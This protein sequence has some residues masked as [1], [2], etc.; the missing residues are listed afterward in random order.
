[1][2]VLVDRDDGVWRVVLEEDDDECREYLPP[3][4]YTAQRVY[5]DGEP[6]TDGIIIAEAVKIILLGGEIHIYTPAYAG[7]RVARLIEKRYSRGQARGRTVR[8]PSP[9][10]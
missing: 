4:E 2:K 6:V 1:M 8:A 7:E 9:P 10:S 5:I 3:E